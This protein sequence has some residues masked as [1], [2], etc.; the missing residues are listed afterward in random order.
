MEVRWIEMM[1]SDCDAKVH[2]LSGVSF[3][4]KLFGELH[5]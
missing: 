3:Q 4:V 5:A 1:A 2:S